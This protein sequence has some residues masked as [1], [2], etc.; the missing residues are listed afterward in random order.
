MTTTFDAYAHLLGLQSN[1]ARIAIFSPVG[2]I[3]QGILSGPTC[4]YAR[5]L[6]ADFR[7]TVRTDDADGTAVHE[8]QVLDPNFW[9]PAHPFLYSLR[10]RESGGATSVELTL[11]LRV[12][13]IREN[14][15]LVNGEPT[16][17]RGFRTGT[18]DEESLRRWHEWKITLLLPETEFDH[19]SIAQTDRLGPFVAGRLGEEKEGALAQMLPLRTS[20]P[21][22]GI[23]MGEQ[24]WSSD[25]WEEL[26][27]FD[28]STLLARRVEVDQLPVGTEAH[29]LVVTGD[30]ASLV[31]A[32]KSEKIGTPWIA[33]MVGSFGVSGFD[34][35]SY[36][37]LANRLDGIFEDLPGC[38]G[39][40]VGG[41]R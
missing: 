31:T 6:P 30:Q 20:A 26:K 24:E 41:P 35:D 36:H 39:W 25:D 28:R 12:L 17:I 15:L 40:V 8:V 9:E 16:F 23:W 38:L 7:L 29:L 13:S 11:G 22:V 5:T 33:D 14:K 4:A 27:R 2:M 21:S 32:A 10:E 1:S 18:L 34:A 37:S 19:D 3:K